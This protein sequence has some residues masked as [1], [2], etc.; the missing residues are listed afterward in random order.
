MIMFEGSAA[1]NR[2][3]KIDWQLS[4]VVAAS[5]WILMYKIHSLHVYPFPIDNNFSLQFNNNNFL[6]INFDNI[7]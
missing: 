3:S 5:F 6:V 7:L 1:E 4:F 2:A